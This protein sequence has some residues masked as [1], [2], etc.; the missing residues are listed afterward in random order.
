M[1]L[2]SHFFS[3]LNSFSFKIKNFSLYQ[4]SYLKQQILIFNSKWFKRQIKDLLVVVVAPFCLFSCPMGACSVVQ[5]EL[6]DLYYDFKIIM[7]KGITREVLV[8]SDSAIYSFWRMGAIGIMLVI[9][10][11]TRWWTW[12][13]KFFYNKKINNN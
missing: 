12:W 2:V 9:P 6:W 1:I 11:A 10:C 4:F 5:A 13:K 3:Q 8:V 7:D